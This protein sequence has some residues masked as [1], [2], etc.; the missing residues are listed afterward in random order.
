MSGFNN[1][2][3]VDI[4]KKRVVLPAIYL[5]QKWTRSASYAKFATELYATSADALKNCTYGFYV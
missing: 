2:K 4:C 5:K 3:T 1:N